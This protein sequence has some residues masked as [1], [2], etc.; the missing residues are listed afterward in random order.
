MALNTRENKDCLEAE[1]G[2]GLS[3]VKT[4]LESLFLTKLSLKTWKGV[5]AA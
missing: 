5:L 1:H 2:H 4:P 3:S